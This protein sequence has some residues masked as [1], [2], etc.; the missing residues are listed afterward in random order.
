MAKQ[1]KSS[2]GAPLQLLDNAKV[3]YIDGRAF[4]PLREAA[5]LG[6]VHSVILEMGKRLL[7]QPN[8]AGASFTL[9]DANMKTRAVEIEA[10]FVKGLRRIAKVLG[11][12]TSVRV[13]SH[14]DGDRLVF[15]YAA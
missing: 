13:R 1:V 12:G 3:E 6:K 11:N 14:R 15:W 2:G 5:K 10:M 7:A 9:G 8:E 4:V